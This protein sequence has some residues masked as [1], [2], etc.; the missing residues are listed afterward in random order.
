MHLNAPTGASVERAGDGRSVPQVP[1]Q[2]QYAGNTGLTAIGPI[3]GKRYRWDHTGATIK[4]DA[5]DAPS[6]GA[7]PNLRRLTYARP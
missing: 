6:M 5:R 2:F 3:T 7:V 4:V 1:V